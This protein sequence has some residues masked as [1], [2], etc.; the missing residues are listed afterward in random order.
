MTEI[1]NP[2]QLVLISYLRFGYYNLGI[3]YYLVLVICYFRL[4]RF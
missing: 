2:K 3:I 4:V 1:Q